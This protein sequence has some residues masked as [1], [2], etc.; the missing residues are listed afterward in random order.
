M[1]CLLDDDEEE[2]FVWGDEDLLLAGAHSEERQGV[3]WVDIADDGASLDCQ[4][5]DVVS[6][7]L[8]GRGCRCLMPLRDDSALLIHNQKSS[9]TLVVTDAIDSL[10]KIGHFKFSVTIIN[11]NARLTYSKI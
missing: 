2:K 7:V 10:L 4:I 9:H 8:R 6:N 5:R 1:V 3:L 11:Q